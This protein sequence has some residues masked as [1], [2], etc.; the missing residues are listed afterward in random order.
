MEI[1]LEGRKYSVKKVGFLG[2]I[3]GLMFS[4][5]INLLFELDNK[6]IIIHS[7]FIFFPIRL[8]FLD[9][10]FDVVEKAVLSPFWLYFPK[11]R[12]KYLVEIPF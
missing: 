5:K 1:V 6:K 7:F 2:S 3:L 9:E 11:C 12:A 4:R 10:R 8:Y